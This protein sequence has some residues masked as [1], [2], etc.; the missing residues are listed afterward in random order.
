MVATLGLNPS[1]REDN[2]LPDEF[3]ALKRNLAA[4]AAARSTSPRRIRSNGIRDDDIMERRK[5]V[6]ERRWPR[7]Q[8]QRRFDFVKRAM[9]HRGNATETR[10]HGD[11]LRAEFFCH[12][13]SQQ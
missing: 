3:A 9:L 1:N 5:P 4:C 10:P 2:W 7:L 6:S 8:D 11:L 12:T 13:K